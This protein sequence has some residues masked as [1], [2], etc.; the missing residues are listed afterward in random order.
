MLSIKITTQIAWVLLVNIQ[1]G[2]PFQKGFILDLKGDYLV[3]SLDALKSGIKKKGLSP[4]V[5]TMK[6]DMHK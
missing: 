1:Q 6:Q 5:L 2:F 4:R 3:S